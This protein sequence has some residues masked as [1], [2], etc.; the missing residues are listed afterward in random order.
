MKKEEEKKQC[1]TQKEVAEIRDMWI[2]HGYEQGLREAKQKIR[3]FLEITK[4]DCE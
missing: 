4:C 2:K 1:F 3:D